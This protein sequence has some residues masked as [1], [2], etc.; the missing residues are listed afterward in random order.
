[1]TASIV[2][3]TA[4]QRKAETGSVAGLC[5]DVQNE[6]G[7]STDSPQPNGEDECYWTVRAVL[8]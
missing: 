6:V 4:D 8:S 3:I 1:M 2:E 5:N 7:E